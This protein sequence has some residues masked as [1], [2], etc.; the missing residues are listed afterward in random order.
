MKDYKLDAFLY[1]ALDYIISTDKEL[2][3]IDLLMQSHR[4]KYKKLHEDYQSAKS[5]L[6]AIYKINASDNKDKTSA[7]EALSEDCK[8]V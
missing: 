2:E 7:I 1:K 8:E 6:R 3:V 5:S 4:G